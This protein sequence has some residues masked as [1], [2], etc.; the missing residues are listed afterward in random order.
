MY[1]RT[2]DSKSVDF[3]IYK[4]VDVKPGEGTSW[5]LVATNSKDGSELCLAT[6]EEVKLA[7]R[8]KESLNEAIDADK[9]W[10]ANE[11][12]ENPYQLP[13]TSRFRIARRN[14]R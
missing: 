11:F 1:I 4:D 2:E 5:Q 3:S 6:F 10:D 9:A 13:K 14:K 7:N 12:K 8:A